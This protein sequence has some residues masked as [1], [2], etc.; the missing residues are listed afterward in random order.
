MKFKFLTTYLCSGAL[1]SCL[2]PH[3]IVIRIG[4][5]ILVLVLF[6]CLVSVEGMDMCPSSPIQPLEV[7]VEVV[8]V[9]R[10]CLGDQEPLPILL[11]LDVLLVRHGPILLLVPIPSIVPA[12]NT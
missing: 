8:L 10:R 12:M 6:N 9:V 3:H 2:Y 5:V 1:S 7:H 11:V 4:D